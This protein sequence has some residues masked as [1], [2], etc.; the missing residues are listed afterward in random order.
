MGSPLNPRSSPSNPTTSAPCL[1]S[2]RKQKRKRRR[3][4]P[5][6]RK[7]GWGKGTRRR[8]GRRGGGETT[9]ASFVENQRARAAAASI[10]I[11]AVPP[12][13][14]QTP[15]R[16]LMQTMRR[17]AQRKTC[18]LKLSAVATAWALNLRTK[19]ATRTLNS[20]AKARTAATQKTVLRMVPTKGVLK[21]ATEKSMRQQRKRPASFALTRCLRILRR[22]RQTE[23][24]SGEWCGRRGA[25]SSPPSPGWA[26]PRRQPGPLLGP[27]ATRT[28]KRKWVP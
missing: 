15:R 11:A 14:K 3:A 5:A 23:R 2:R 22:E 1:P 6:M 28:R 9:L 20:R 7:L 18:R 27:V 25:L 13:Q 8:G 4:E 26:T 19:T 12:F 21:E 10:V 24:L 16:V 17:R